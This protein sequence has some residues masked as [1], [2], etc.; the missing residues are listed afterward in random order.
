MLCIAFPRKVAAQ[1]DFSFNTNDFSFGV[2]VK[3]NVEFSFFYRPDFKLGIT[4]GVSYNAE[5]D[6]SY[7]ISPALHGGFL[8]FNGRSVGADQSRK[9]YSIQSHAFL[10]TTAVFQLDRLDTNPLDRPVPLYHFAEFTA[11]PLQNPYKSSVSYGLNL[12]WVHE[13][14]MQRTGFFNL[15]VAGRFQVSYYNDGGPILGWAGDNRDRY[16]TGGVVFSYHGATND[17]VNLIELSYHKFTG[18]Q[19]YAFDVADQLQI[20][21]LNYHDIEQFKYNQQRWRLNITNLEH[22]FGG[23]FS[24]YNVN[25]LDFQDFLH[26]ATNVPYH[27]DYFKGYRWMIGGRYEYNSTQL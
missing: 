6:N 18:Y 3:L 1:N 17:E 9:Q 4:G 12:I 23:S 25:R 7:G 19:E 14:K 24:L 11:N 16:Y 22:G 27:P 8:F 5:F 26:F 20:D 2:G 13:W 15:N 10:N 21:F